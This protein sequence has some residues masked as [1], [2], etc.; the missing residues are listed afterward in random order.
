MIKSIGQLTSEIYGLLEKQT[1]EDKEKVLISVRTLLGVKISGI[2]SGTADESEDSNTTEEDNQNQK[3]KFKKNDAKAY[4][5]GKKPQ[6]KGEEFAVAAMFRIEGGK[7]NVHT[8]DDFKEVIKNQARLT[9]FDEKNFARDMTNAKRQAGFF[10]N[11][12]NVGEYVLSGPGED[13]V[14]AL[15]DRDAAKQF[16]KSKGGSKKAKKKKAAK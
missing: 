6:N 5:A 10:I 8:K 11:G 14:A 3:P 12:N 7:E 15:P 13:Y 4:F 9:T 2:G 1:P 16:R